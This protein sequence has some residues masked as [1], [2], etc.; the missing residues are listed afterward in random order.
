MCVC[1]SE[2][3]AGS[4]PAVRKGSNAS[5]KR[6]VQ[7]RA[8]SVRATEL[9]DRLWRRSLQLQPA[10]Q[11]FGDAPRLGDAS[12]RQV[13]RVG[14]EYFADLADARL[15]EPLI[16]SG[17]QFAEGRA[18]GAGQLQRRVDVRAD[19]PR[20]DGA[21]MIRGVARPQIAIVP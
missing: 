18:I 19:Q 13:R 4:T 8:S 16:E 17:E 20:P 9:A 7:P 3:R 11:H 10:S 21:L 12:A 5:A 6:G 15:V 1:S 2:T 14:I